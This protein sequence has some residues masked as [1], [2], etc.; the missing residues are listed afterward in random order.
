MVTPDGRVFFG[1][2]NSGGTFL[3]WHPDTGLTT[4]IPVGPV[5]P[6]AKSTVLVGDGRV[7]FGTG[8]DPVADTNS[9]GTRSPGKCAVRSSCSDCV[10][11]SRSK[12]LR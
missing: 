5:F 3:S 2:G 1:Q 4:I 12:V 7:F 10:L 8:Y 9:A 6:G 11:C